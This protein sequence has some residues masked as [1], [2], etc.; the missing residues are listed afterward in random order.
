MKAALT[1]QLLNIYLL[2][3]CARKYCV[4]E[5]EHAELNDLCASPTFVP[6]CS[7]GHAGCAS[8]CRSANTH[9]TVLSILPDTM[10]LPSG[11]AAMLSTDSTCTG[12]AAALPPAVTSHKL[13]GPK[14]AMVQN[15]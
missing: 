14:G 2:R 5:K 13:G 11:L 15:K 12:E 1:I 6:Y 10:V 7:R 4:G 8:A 9:R 3:T